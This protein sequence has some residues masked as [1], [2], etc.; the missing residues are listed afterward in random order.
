MLFTSYKFI[1]IFLPVVFAGYVTFNK[2]K[3]Y[4]LSKIWLI[5]VS[6][7]FYSQ[8]TLKFLP[9]FVGTVLLNYFIGIG[10][11]KFREVK[12]T[13]FARILLIF[14]LI[15]NLGLLGY[16]KYKNFFMEN[17]HNILGTDFTLKEIMLP[18]GISFFTFH[19]ISF[20]VDS[21]KEDM[22]KLCLKQSGS[23][24]QKKGLKQQGSFGRYYDF[25][26]YMVYV[27]FFP[28]L[29]M[30]PIVNHGELVS[31]IEN[32]TKVFVFKKENIMMG[33][34]MFSIGC[35]KKI[36]LADPL[37]GHAQAFYN[38]AG[39]TGFF[40]SWSAVLAYTFAYYFDFSGYG[41]MAIGLGLFF[42]IKLPVNFNS[43]YKS[44][45]FLEFWRRWNITLY[46]FLNRYVYNSIH[47]F[48][49]RTLKTMF[50]IIITFLVS[51]IWHGAGWN[52]IAW[53]LVNGV[54]VSICTLMALHSKKLPFPIAWAI[55]FFGVLMT[56]VIFDSKNMAQ[57]M[58]VYKDMFNLTGNIGGLHAFL[59]QGYHFFIDNWFIM[60]LIVICVLI[61]FIPKNSNQ[62]IEDFKPNWKYP[63]FAAILLVLTLFR[64]G[65]VSNFLYFQF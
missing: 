52:Y 13:A 45:N 26:D 29:I 47:R 24:K 31:Q 27:T 23:L 38:G 17:V 51:G 37:I 7:Y 57:V 62:M 10:I 3:L 49:H 28:H 33:M 39:G 22:D 42:N 50:A 19:L 64:M 18:L 43:P 36:L 20:L 63:A 34:F 12:R 14:G 32:K 48:G 59:S 61:S 15:E 58:D 46:N 44:R 4:K 65:S 53:G 55:T 54:F 6:L 11:V 41:D 21:Y 56:R 40:S 60:V 8:G 9:L 35:A 25:I 2:F 16:F 5:A 30:G 1:L